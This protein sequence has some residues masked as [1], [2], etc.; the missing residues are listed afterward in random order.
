LSSDVSSSLS[1]KPFIIQMPGAKRNKTESAAG[2]G[3]I[4]NSSSSG[5]EKEGGEEGE[6]H[7]YDEE[8]NE[9]VPEFEVLEYLRQLQV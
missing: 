2:P 5:K 3:V 1:R 4:A 8:L 9:L 7:L 6:E